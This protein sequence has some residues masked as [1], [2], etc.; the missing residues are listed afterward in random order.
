MEASGN[1]EVTQE[2]EQERGRTHG[3][4]KKPPGHIRKP[5]SYQETPGS[6]AEAPKNCK[7]TEKG[8]EKAN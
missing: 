2:Y 7:E 6:R 3:S 4:S 5:Q 8:T 1:N